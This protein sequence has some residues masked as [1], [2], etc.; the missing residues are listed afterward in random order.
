MKF[1]T[2]YLCRFPRP[3]EVVFDQGSEFKSEF[4]E[5]LLSYGIKAI[6]TIVRNPVANA[7]IK[8]T[9]LTMGD[10]LRTEQAFV[11]NKHN[12]WIDEV[13]LMLQ[14]IV[15]AMQVTIILIKTTIIFI[16]F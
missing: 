16:G 8:R 4:I 1:D 2:H 10:M 15:F 9:H 5:L 3:T 13:N 7:I 6:P 12:T 14:G 11:L